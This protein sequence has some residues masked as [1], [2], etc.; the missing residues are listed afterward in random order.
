MDPV[1]LTGGVALVPGMAKAL[2]LALGRPVKIV[3][4]A[5]LTGAIGAAILAAR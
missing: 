4:Q 5:Q 2:Q 1:V 3:P